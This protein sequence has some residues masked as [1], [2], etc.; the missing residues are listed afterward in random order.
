[1]NNAITYA[2]RYI[3]RDIPIRILNE[4]FLKDVPYSR[5]TVRNLESIIKELVIDGVV[6]PDADIAGGRELRLDIR[7]LNPMF[8]ENGGLTYKIPMEMT[9]GTAINSVRWASF[10]LTDAMASGYGAP[11]GYSNNMM[12]TNSLSG[13]VANVMNASTPD[14]I[15]GTADCHVGPA[16]DNIVFVKCR[17]R[18]KIYW[19]LVSAGYDA[20]F[21]QISPKS[22]PDFAE[23]CL[24]ATKAYIWTKLIVDM[25]E[26]KISAGSELGSFKSIIDGF[27]DA[28]KSYNEYLREHMEVV[29]MLND[30]RSKEEHY[31]MYTGGRRW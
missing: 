23:L 13:A 30:P 20:M 19:L 2:L 21:N 11:T 6:G 5:G 9:G 31:F 29:F 22:Y 10:V 15:T 3:K 27:S 17:Q 14:P 25:D 26:G 24:L 7:D 28:G 12:I 1:M 8:S 16:G 4:V 18:Q